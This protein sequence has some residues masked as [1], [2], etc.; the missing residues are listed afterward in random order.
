MENT[1]IRSARAEDS[2]SVHRLLCLLE[3]TNLDPDVTE[4]IFGEILASPAHRVLVAECGG[5]VAGML[6]LRVEAQLHH[7]GIVAEIMELCVAE[8]FRARGIGAQLVAAAQGEAKA[9]GAPLLEVAC[10]RRR[11]AAHRFYEREGFSRS[12][13]RFSRQIA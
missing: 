13:F 1:P 9:M 5:A 4:R 6:H 8:E 7:A 3:D 11:E 12:H 2:G 10:N